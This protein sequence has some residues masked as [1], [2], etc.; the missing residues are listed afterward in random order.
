MAFGSWGY[1]FMCEIFVS[2]Q[3]YY[4]SILQ[5]AALV[6]EENALMM[7]PRQRDRDYLHNSMLPYNMRIA[8]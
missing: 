8:S 7:K 3:I 2:M 6:K 4:F 5:M 1:M